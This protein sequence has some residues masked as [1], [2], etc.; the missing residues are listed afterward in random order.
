MTVPLS[1]GNDRAVI[2][3]K[4]GGKL[5]SLVAGG[6]ERIA[7]ADAGMDPVTDVLQFG[8]FLMIPWAGRLDAGRLPWDGEVYELPQNFFG[9]AIHGVGF[10][11]E[12][13]IEAHSDTAVVLTLDLGAAGWPF[14][15]TAS[16]HIALAPGSLELRAEVVAGSKSMP[17]AAGW[18]PY[19]DRPE[20]GDLSI[21]V[22]AENV[23][24]TREDLIPTGGLVPVGGDTDLREGPVL[25]DRRLDHVYANVTGPTV[26]SWP[27]LELTQDLGSEI[28]TVVVYTPEGKACCEPQTAWPNAPELEAKGV[29]TTGLAH[30]PA[31]ATWSTTT[32]WTWRTVS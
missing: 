28:S 18:H 10:D 29:T 9:H 17:V 4:V 8:S 24:E 2:D 11:K 16:H 15:G 19:F 13:L 21:R 22:N 27:D 26:V 30:L 23:L 7:Q 31:G 25:G 14:G 6:V 5:T 1:A 20:S 3:E 32:T 12:W